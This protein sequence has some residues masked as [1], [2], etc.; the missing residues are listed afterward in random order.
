MAQAPTTGTLPDSPA[1]AAETE[2]VPAAPARTRAPRRAPARTAAAKGTAV[3]TVAPTEQ[4]TAEGTPAARQPA[5]SARATR[6]R[7]THAKAT[8]AGAGTDE[9]TTGPTPFA[10]ATT[11]DATTSDATASDATASDATT[12]T[13]TPTEPPRPKTTR[14]RSTRAK[15][16]SAEATAGAPAVEAA[17]VKASRAQSTRSRAK[18]APATATEQSPLPGA[19][20]G[21][22]PGR[23]A[24]RAGAGLAGLADATPEPVETRVSSPL[25]P[26]GTGDLG[27]LIRLLIPDDPTTGPVPIPA[28][29]PDTG[30]LIL[31]PID[32]PFLTPMA[33][34][35]GPLTV[36]LAYRGWDS[37][38]APGGAPDDATAPTSPGGAGLAGQATAPVGGSTTGESAVGEPTTVAAAEWPVAAAAATRPGGAEPDAEGFAVVGVL[39]QRRRRWPWTRWRWTRLPLPASWPPPGREP[40]SRRWPRAL[41]W[42][43]DMSWERTLRQP[44]FRRWL[45]AVDWEETLGRPRGRYLLP[46]LIWPSAPRRPSERRW[47]SAGRSLSRPVWARGNVDRRFAPVYA[48]A[49]SPDGRRLA[50]ASGDGLVR[51]WNVADPGVPARMWEVS[52]RFAAG[53][54]VAFSPDGTWL[55]TGHDNTHAV[56]WKIDELAGPVPRALLAHP[57][58]LTGLHF[59]ADGRRLAAGFAA[60]AARIWDVTDPTHPRPL[61]RAGDSRL[62]RA[63]AIF[64]N[65]R[66]LATAGERV[67]FWEVSATPVRRMHLTAG[68]GPL[69]DVA[70]APDGRTMAVGRLDGTVDL[71]HTIDPSAPAPRASINAHAGW[72]TSVTFSAD[73]RWL[74]TVSAEHVA[75]WDLLDPT[76]AVGRIRTRLPVTAVAFAPKRGLLAVAS[77]DGSVTLLRPT[78]EAH[79]P[80]GADGHAATDADEAR[81]R[82][83]RADDE[84]DAE[85]TAV[86]VE[87]LRTLR[88]MGD[89]PAAGGIDLPGRR[90][91]ERRTNGRAAVVGGLAIGLSC[92]LVFGHQLGLPPALLLAAGMIV[93]LALVVATGLALAAAVWAP[94]AA[95]PRQAAGAG[96][97]AARSAGRRTR[98]AHTRSASRPPRPGPRT[99]TD[100][101]TARTNAAEPDEE[102]PRDAGA[103][104]LSATLPLGLVGADAVGTEDDGM[105]GHANAGAEAVVTSPWNVSESTRPMP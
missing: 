103:S 67:E 33:D 12:A 92:L 52:T 38:T 39:E 45:P 82:E 59:S 28:P 68:E 40:S 97:P 93:V 75:L 65:G 66:W 14:T 41:R 27:E 74:A 24:Q 80:A 29:P 63:A 86:D 2:A 58:G 70:V 4:A 105:G 83:A 35:T 31:P 89:T 16:P 30:P 15:A 23:A 22:A 50:T 6:A 48:V 1:P 36:P 100:P 9:A 26:T 19:T 98:G 49:F 77:L 10:D 11:S 34:E 13:A 51:L 17:P 18:A 7:P 87:P 61:G 84:T 54:V 56:L 64:P 73:S 21:P 78:T 72:V 60:E 85:K 99:A 37:P 95:G 20:A 104:P 53:P 55:A 76:A 57:G 101:T 94:P 88:P 43:L 91:R 3:T 69:L 46:A 44:R 90:R 62:I 5:P 71:W 25:S 102:Q 8:P 42:S 47:Q 79:E 32:G 81:V 96:T